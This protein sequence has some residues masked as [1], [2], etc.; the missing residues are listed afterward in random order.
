MERMEQ[1]SEI[2]KYAVT[3]AVDSILVEVGS[4]LS[5]A[6]RL[7]KEQEEVITQ[8]IGEIVKTLETTCE[9]DVRTNQ[10]LY[11]RKYLIKRRETKK[12]Q[13]FML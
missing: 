10:H 1:E 2:S 12:C 11:T 7:F 9:Q 5:H 6:E 4:L 3:V 8:D 13:T